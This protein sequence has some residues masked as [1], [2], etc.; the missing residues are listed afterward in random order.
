MPTDPVLPAGIVSLTELGSAAETGTG[1]AITV[2]VAPLIAC[3]ALSAVAVSAVQKV[4]SN[5]HREGNRIEH[6]HLV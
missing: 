3:Q 2:N 4:M 6:S 1:S 5:V